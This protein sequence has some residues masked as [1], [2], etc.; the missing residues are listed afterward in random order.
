MKIYTRINFIMY[1]VISI[2]ILYH[3]SRIEDKLGFFIMFTLG[4]WVVLNFLVLLFINYD[5]IDDYYRILGHD[6]KN[7]YKETIKIIKFYLNI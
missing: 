1:W 6:L 3:Y 7:T 4:Y 2:F 5:F